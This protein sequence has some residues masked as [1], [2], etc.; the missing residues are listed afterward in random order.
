MVILKML[1]NTSY[2]VK[3]ND[4]EIWSDDRIKLL[5]DTIS[6]LK[7]MRVTWSGD[8]RKDGYSPDTRYIRCGILIQVLYFNLD[9]MKFH[10]VR[11]L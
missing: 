2:Y 3:L 6:A 5:L 8:N 9:N 11:L 1:K 4:Q 7:V 10:D